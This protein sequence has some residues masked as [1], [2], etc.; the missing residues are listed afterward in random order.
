MHFM[1]STIDCTLYIFK[2]KTHNKYFNFLLASHTG[3]ADFL[4]SLLACQVSCMYISF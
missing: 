3:Q 4:S 2:P 1:V